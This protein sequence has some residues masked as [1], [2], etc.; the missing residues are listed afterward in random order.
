MCGCGYRC[1]GVS[2]GVGV[3]VGVGV[4]GEREKYNA[5]FLKTPIQGDL[6]LDSKEEFELVVT[7]HSMQT[8]T[9]MTHN[10]QVNTQNHV[11]LYSYMYTHDHCFTARGLL[12]RYKKHFEVFLSTGAR[13]CY[14]HVLG[15]KITRI[16]VKMKA[17]LCKPSAQCLLVT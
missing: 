17:Q 8:N 11:A 3:G 16:K 10:K 1:V 7:C 5:S 12:T 14:I 13:Y 9:T 15:T 4:W 6:E 2:V